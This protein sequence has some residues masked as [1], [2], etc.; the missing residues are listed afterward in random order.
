VEVAI[1]ELID[2]TI[3]KSPLDRQGVL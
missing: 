2:K 3:A 1:C